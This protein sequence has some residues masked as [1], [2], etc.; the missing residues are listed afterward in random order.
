MQWR[1]V[2]RRVRA[3]DYGGGGW[4]R[5]HH[6]GS[7]WVSPPRA[8]TGP[9]LAS[10]RGNFD[11]PARDF[12]QKKTKKRKIPKR[13]KQCAH[14]LGFRSQPGTTLL[15]REVRGSGRR[16]AL[17]EIAQKILKNGSIQSK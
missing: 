16:S 12:E 7:P 1:A 15:G 6:R 8:S 14:S 13:K 5:S 2:R 3:G 17:Q 4:V 9:Q 10:R 11:Q